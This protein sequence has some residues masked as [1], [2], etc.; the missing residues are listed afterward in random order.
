MSKAGTH[1]MF[2]NLPSSR[3]LKQVARLNN[4][5]GTAETAYRFDASKVKKIEL[6]F[7]HQNILGAAVGLKKFWRHNL[8]TL[9]FHNDDINFVCTRINAETKEEAEKCPT[10]IIIHSPDN[11]KTELN[12]SAK[13]SSVI[14]QELIK[15]TG[16]T[17]VPTSEIPVVKSPAAKQTLF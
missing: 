7:I 5:A 17:S 16:A 11:N 3:I 6:L 1:A 2:K 13:H 15:A 9:K 12:C 10:K 14:L 8:P 4:I